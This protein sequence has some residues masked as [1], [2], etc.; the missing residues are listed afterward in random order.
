MAFG[1]AVCFGKIPTHGDF[2]RHNAY[3]AASRLFDAWCRDG[4][5]QGRIQF[6][7]SGPSGEEGR[8]SIAFVA[9]P[10]TDDSL[11]AGV[12]R[13]SRDAAG[14]RYPLVVGYEWEGRPSDPAGI[15][16]LPM[17]ARDAFRRAEGLLRRAVDGCL[18]PDLLTDAVERG[19]TG[20]ETL[21]GRVP[22]AGGMDWAK[23]VSVRAFAETVWGEFDDTRKYIVFKSLLDSLAP[24]RGR[25]PAGFRRGLRF[26]IG[27]ARGAM[28]SI[29]ARAWVDGALR[30][31]NAPGATPTFF[32]P[33]ARSSESNIGAGSTARPKSEH[34]SLLLFLRPPPVSAFSMLLPGRD[35]CETVSDLEQQGE[36]DPVRCALS[37]P[38]RLGRRLESADDTLADVLSSLSGR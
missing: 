27:A 25:L 30:V 15:A 9:C 36:N 11:L 7:R 31:L 23:A 22:G 34:P 35:D 6:G 2:V 14:R 24:L 13:W 20:W 10:T 18:S 33:V 8:T 19:R 4:L 3:G 12:F 21:D 17:S 26:P 32:W 28:R 16:A 38:P 1:R 37:L 29:I 5:Y